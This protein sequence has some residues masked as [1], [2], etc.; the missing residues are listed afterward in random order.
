MQAISF[1]QNQK[2]YVDFQ[3]HGGQMKQTPHYPM[4]SCI[5]VERAL[6]IGINT[7]ALNKYWLRRKNHVSY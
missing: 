4:G 2:L 5:Y 3:L 1:L 6:R 7:Q